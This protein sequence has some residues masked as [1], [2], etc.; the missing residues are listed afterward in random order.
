MHK[1]KFPGQ[2]G[3][4]VA[5]SEYIIQ[6]ATQAGLDD[7]QVYEVQLAVDEAATNIIEHAYHDTDKGVI[8]CSYEILP[9][10]IKVILVDR[11]K[12][13][14]PADVPEPVFT[15]D[16]EEVKP[17]GLGIFIMRKV[18]DEVRFDISAGGKNTCTMVKYAKK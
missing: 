3:S 5:I 16:I 2:F 17:R 18:M 4:L 11:G 15:T 14:D 9:N 6:A 12:P 13:F 1:K 8:E 7:S 10:G